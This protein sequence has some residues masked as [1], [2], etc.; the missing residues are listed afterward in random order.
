MPGS[1]VGVVD[2]VLVDVFQHFEPSSFAGPPGNVG[3]LCLRPHLKI[4]SLLIIFI[5]TNLQKA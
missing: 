4:I 5:I 2:L 1:A 3:F